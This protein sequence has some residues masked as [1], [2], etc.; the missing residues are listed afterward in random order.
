MKCNSRFP[1]H[2]HQPSSFFLILQLFSIFSIEDRQNFLLPQFCF[3]HSL[4][5]RSQA[6]HT[7]LTTDSPVRRISHFK[8]G[9]LG[10]RSY[11]PGQG[12]TECQKFPSSTVLLDFCPHVSILD[13]YCWWVSLSFPFQLLQCQTTRWRT[14][15]LMAGV[16]TNAISWAVFCGEQLWGSLFLRFSNYL[17]DPF[18]QL[19]GCC[20]WNTLTFWYRFIPWV[21]LAVKHSL[22]GGWDWS[23]SWQSVT[24]GH[25]SP[26]I[27]HLTL[28]EVLA[29]S[30]SAHARS[31]SRC[32]LLDWQICRSFTLYFLP[33]ESQALGGNVSAECHHNVSEGRFSTLLDFIFDETL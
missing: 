27:L 9:E 5:S 3:D 10:Q 6:P 31:H 13:I 25:G 21:L 20:L 7:I 4:L 30:L 29:M 24:E 32:Q 12:C 18:T 11:R 8:D 14:N 16:K 2:L 17:P 23:P 22:L 19:Q 1:P 33:P 26:C 15:G 28:A